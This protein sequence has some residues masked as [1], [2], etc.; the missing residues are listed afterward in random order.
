MENILNNKVRTIKDDS[1][2]E[3][4][5]ESIKKNNIHI[6]YDTYLVSFLEK[7]K[8]IDEVDHVICKYNNSELVNFFYITLL[9][10]KYEF[11]SEICENK[12]EKNKIEKIL[13][14]L[15]IC[16]I[17]HTDN[18]KKLSNI[19]IESVD[20]CQKCLMIYYLSQKKFLEVFSFLIKRDKTINFIK[21][22]IFKYNFYRIVNKFISPINNDNINLVILELLLNGTRIFQTYFNFLLDK[23]KINK[24]N[25]K[26]F[27]KEF[28]NL[29]ND[30]IYDILKK[31]ADYESLIFFCNLLFNEFK[32]IKILLINM[33]D[34]NEHEKY[35]NENLDEMIIEKKTNLE[36]HGNESLKNK[37]VNNSNLKE[38]IL[39]YIYAHVF[40]LLKHKYV[41]TTVKNVLKEKIVLYSLMFNSLRYSENF[42]QLIIFKI[43]NYYFIND[44]NFLNESNKK[45]ISSLFSYWIKLLDA[46]VIKMLDRYLSTGKNNSNRNEP[47]LS[48]LKN[49]FVDYDIFKYMQS[50]ISGIYLLSL[51][52]KK[53][54]KDES[55]SLK[56]KYNIDSFLNEYNIE[57][58]S[59]NFLINDNFIYFIGFIF[60]E[61]KEIVNNLFNLIFKLIYF[62]KNFKFYIIENLNLKNKNF[63]DTLIFCCINIIYNILDGT[64][65]LF[66]NSFEIDEYTNTLYQKDLK[67]KRTFDN[68]ALYSFYS[69]INHRD[70]YIRLYVTKVIIILF[71]D[72]SIRDSVEKNLFFE[73][74]DSLMNIEFDHDKIKKNEER[75]NVN[76]LLL[77]LFKTNIKDD[78]SS[79]KLTNIIFSEKQK[80]FIKYLAH[81]CNDDF[82][83]LE[84]KNMF[85]YFFILFV[86]IVNIIIK[87]AQLK[88]SIEKYKIL[89]MNIYDIIEFFLCELKK[90]KNKKLRLFFFSSAIYLCHLISNEIYKEK[91]HSSIPFLVVVMDLIK[92]IES[93]L[94]FMYDDFNKFNN[95]IEETTKEELYYSSENDTKS[96][97]DLHILYF[98]DNVYDENIQNNENNE[99]FNY[100]NNINNNSDENIQIFS[101]DKMNRC[102]KYMKKSIIQNK[103]NEKNIYNYINAFFFLC[104]SNPS[105]TTKKNI[106]KFFDIIIKYIIRD[107]YKINRVKKKSLIFSLPIVIIMDQN[108]EQK[109]YN[110]I[111]DKYDYILKTYIVDLFKSK[112]FLPCFFISVF[113][114]T[115]TVI[116]FLKRK[117]FIEI[118]LNKKTD[119]LDSF[120]LI[121]SKTWFYLNVVIEC[122]SKY[123]NKNCFDDFLLHIINLIIDNIWKIIIYIF[124]SVELNTFSLKIKMN[125]TTIFLRDSI[126]LFLNFY[127]TWISFTKNFSSK[128][129]TPLFIHILP[130]LFY[131]KFSFLSSQ[132]LNFFNFIECNFSYISLNETN[133]TLLIK[134]K[135]I[136]NNI[137]DSL[138]HLIKTRDSKG[139]EN[140]LN[141]LIQF[142][143]K[144]KKLVIPKNIHDL[145]LPLEYDCIFNKIKEIK[146][147]NEKRNDIRK[148][149]HK[150]NK[151]KNDN[152]IFIEKEE[153][154]RHVNNT[155]TCKEKGELGN[156]N[157]KMKKCKSNLN[158]PDLKKKNDYSSKSLS[159]NRNGNNQIVIV[160]DN[161][162]K[163]VKSIPRSISNSRSPSRYLS[164]RE[165]YKENTE[166]KRNIQYCHINQEFKKEIALQKAKKIIEKNAALKCQ[167][168]AII[169][170][171]KKLEKNKHQYFKEMKEKRIEVENS[172]NKYF[173]MLQE[174]LEWDFFDL[175]NIQ[176][177]K[178]CIN[179]EIPI[180][181]KNEEEYHKYFRP[182]A[183]EECRCCILN[184]MCGET[185]K[186]VINI[187]GKQKTSYWIIWHIT[188]S[189]ENKT[190]LDILKPMDLIALI[191]FETE[192]I[193]GDKGTIKYEDLKRILK[194]NKHLLGLIDVSSNKLENI[195]DI[196]LINEDVF[197]S[198]RKNEENRLKLN[199]LSCNKFHVYLLCN[200]MTYIRE[201]QSVYMTKCSPLFNLILN[202]NATN[203]RENKS[204]RNIN[205]NDNNIIENNNKI[206]E[207]KE[208]LSNYENLILKTMRNYN[209]LN[210]SQIEAVKLVFLNKNN[211]SLIQ[212]PPGTGKT[213]TV[214]GIVSA[215]YALIK[216][217]YKNEKKND[218]SFNE[219]NVNPKKILVCS[220][221][222]SAIDEIAKRI[223]NEGLINFI[224]LKK[225]TKNKNSYE[226]EN[227]FHD[228]TNS[229]YL[230]EKGKNV[231]NEFNSFKKQTIT[232]KCIRI[233]I[234][235]KTH[236]E[237]QHISLDYIFNKRK[238]LEQNIYDSHFN[239]KKKKLSYSIKAIDYACQKINEIRMNLNINNSKKFCSDI[240]E[241]DEK[242]INK[243]IENIE[244]FFSEELINNVDKAYLEN[245]L[246]LFNESFSHYEWS[247]EKLNSEKKNFEEKKKKLLE[248]DNEI[249]SFY[250]NS[251]KD[252]MISESEVI[253]STLS[254]SASPLIEN[255]EFE[256]LIIDEA[257]QCVELSCLIPF[258]LKIKSIIMVGDPKQLPS[259]TF[260]SDCRRYG[261]SRS[262]FERLLSCNVPSV[263]LNIQYR[264]RPEICYFPNKYFYNG[265]IKND[266]NLI[267]KPFFYFHYLN[268]F[269]CYKF[270][271]IDGIES[272][273]YNKSYINYVE[274]YFIFKLILYFQNFIENKNKK[275]DVSN[276]YIL[277]TNFN[278]K[279]IG[280]ICPY[281][282]QVHLI[283]KMFEGV[284]RDSYSPE[285]STV[286][287]FQGREKNIIIFSCVRSNLQSM[288]IFK[289]IDE[290]NVSKKN[291]SDILNYELNDKKVLSLKNNNYINNNDFNTV[292]KFRNNI[293]FLKDERRLNVALT[294]AKDALWIIGNKKNLE[295]NETWNSLIKNAITRN[296]YSDLKL[297]FHKSTT[298]E[299]IKE[300]INDFF[301]H[302]DSD[303]NNTN[304]KHEN[305]RIYENYSTNSLSSKNE[306]KTDSKKLYNKKKKLTKKTI[307]E[308]RNK[309]KKNED[310]VIQYKRENNFNKDNISKNCINYN[311]KKNEIRENKNI[312]KK[313]KRSE[314]EEIQKSEDFSKKRK[315]N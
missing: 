185:Y 306:S 69:F 32:E 122:L 272:I 58:L 146:M 286:D 79:N 212:G 260:S 31:Y 76:N 22:E 159:Q 311:N 264:M 175:E 88:L 5:K 170:N 237:I 133:I 294:R 61:N 191:P 77:L 292:E 261:Y 35:V 108:N 255:L 179:K 84:L 29:D 254:G 112:K 251:N 70:Y 50:L 256:Y 59:L 46:C 91:I 89:F 27:T 51:I 20:N 195:Y 111:I 144:L 107:E 164:P 1:L 12:I 173:I 151:Y 252:F 3:N 109:R 57:N 198:K 154:I 208:N 38:D 14:N 15:E 241:T 162:K 298:E 145:S 284:F 227:N 305:Y 245:L 26:N 178:N 310:P 219:Q 288:E 277:P 309:Y 139:Y 238:K 244:K 147:N 128:K 243:K 250:S 279:D 42:I 258:R 149:E 18:L 34:K 220:P 93:D 23:N 190:N 313:N 207:N 83:I 271:N 187:V 73:I 54:K 166:E 8:S 278:L 213:K 165:K 132:I 192:N 268:L 197:P 19:I 81:I 52:K 211:I 200:L 289:N 90:E 269:G 39:H 153:N 138:I 210:E 257:C 281:Q 199:F 203:V 13:E 152:Q 217:L 103:E 171:E 189:S 116:L 181:F 74:F 150:G 16:K 174:F 155:G 140:E 4:L 36:N 43:I 30:N 161:M 44:D 97:K 314:Y 160:S 142:K 135:E 215:L 304:N 9:V 188:S 218:F 232:P 7:L 130:E 280:I 169:L 47:E 24:I 228:N 6:L 224:D 115:N 55:F 193:N 72:V 137:L 168:R 300:R 40:L 233:G 64:R 206:K 62:V 239:N 126:L 21:K 86:K 222:N 301:M 105:Q 202:P 303:L 285:I 283:K 134:Q 234:S 274:A 119:I 99:H 87:R 37:S 263:L 63:E 125:N 299:K 80:V 262:L 101:F 100:M 11:I 230:N 104:V 33:K 136:M 216:H 127:S 204:Y 194:L 106:I 92:I 270:I 121:N 114:F 117:N 17:S 273:T 231:E 302:M 229:K 2:F 205:L 95:V 267:N 28:L 312:Q 291:T 249:G 253:F 296:C 297:N 118:N 240:N 184:K 53:K 196:K 226:N 290:L 223:L 60:S 201:F 242:A 266:E 163:F 98:Y 275:N 141:N 123:L 131:K 236:E 120:M 94:S 315:L 246:Y 41:E 265:S 49:S 143:L 68:I 183:L 186:F 259:T 129:Y 48:F 158:V 287:A 172:I 10:D 110:L 307:N 157:N 67:K 45:L 102:K 182:M 293:G 295:K 282:S 66:I 247:I 148:D 248:T 75:K 25:L 308:Y 225:E 221:S 209:L 85:E 177:Y 176:K 113:C 214:I 167:K 180:R 156:E 276:L 71:S 65:K 96:T 56:E 78:R 82:C 124:Y 235:K